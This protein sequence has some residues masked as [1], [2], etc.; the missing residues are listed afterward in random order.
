MTTKVLMATKVQM[1]TK[2]TVRT[3]STN[4][5]KCNSR[6]FGF[7]CH[8]IWACFFWT[9]YIFSNKQNDKIRY[10]SER[11]LVNWKMVFC[12][13]AT[14]SQVTRFNFT[15][16][17]L[18]CICVCVCIILKSTNSM[19]FRKFRFRLNSWQLSY[20][21]MIEIISVFWSRAWLVCARKE[22]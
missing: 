1:A 16:S 6:G 21:F 3:K 17:R 5:T 14:T 12:K 2:S 20:F 9:M 4:R 22:N 10:F 15:K 18:H 7:I 13:T 8:I 11:Q 19:D